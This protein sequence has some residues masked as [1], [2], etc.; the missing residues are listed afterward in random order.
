AGGVRVGP[1]G[2]EFLAPD[3]FLAAAAR[4]LLGRRPGWPA[5]AGVGMSLVGSQV[6]HRVAAAAGRPAC[7]YPP[8]FRWF[9]DGLFDGTLGFAG[10][11][12]RASFL[13]FD[14]TPWATDGDGLALALLAAEMTA[15]TGKDVGELGREVAAAVGP[16]DRTRIDLPASPEVR[17]WLRGPPPEAVGPATRA[18]EPVTAV[19]TRAQ[20]NGVP[21]GGVKVV[22]PGGWFAALAS[23]ADD[24]CTV[25][26]ESF[27]GPDHLGRIVEDAR[28][29][30]TP[31]RDHGTGGGR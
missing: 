12:T 26:A 21:A 9:A 25:Y 5:R 11:G 23:E 6:I 27:R 13:R 8:G 1:A 17:A 15:R 18:G 29:V 28:R 22:A 19:L 7:Q 3:G 16:A 4:Y 20:G 24:A 31:P 14:G 10:E 2:G 30:V